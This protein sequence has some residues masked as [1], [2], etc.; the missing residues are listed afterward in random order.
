MDSERAGVHVTDRVD[1]A[2][3]SPCTAHVQSGERARLAKARKVEEGV[4]GEHAVALGHQPVVKLHLLLGGGMK[5][6]PNV[7]SPAGRTQPRNPQGGAV[8]CCQSSEFV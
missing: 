4:T 3:H 1:E 6:V 2:H 7:G 5:V 8:T